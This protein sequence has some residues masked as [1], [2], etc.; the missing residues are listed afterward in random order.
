MYMK[1][2]HHHK[3]SLGSA[4]LLLF[5]LL[6][7]GYATA[8]QV[9][10]TKEAVYSDGSKATTIY[11]DNGNYA[12]LMEMPCVACKGSGVCT[13]CKGYGSM[14]VYNRISRC[15]S[16]AGIG[17]CSICGGVGKHYSNCL[18][19]AYGTQITGSST[20]DNRTSQRKSSESQNQTTTRTCTL[21]GGT[22]LVPNSRQDQA[23]RILGGE[24]H[25]CQQCGQKHAST[26]HQNCSVC[27]GTGQKTISSSGSYGQS[28]SQGRSC[29]HCN[30]T[31]LVPNS[32]QDQTIRILGGED[33]MCR[34]CGQKH[35]S[36][37]HES[38]VFCQGSGRR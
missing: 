29:T 25:M 31:G 2:N 12:I 13:F 1:T 30:G 9:V 14:R 21:C 19:D 16:C 7:T 22:G 15:T 24:D 28:Q 4:L 3:V 17:K 5:L 8:Q 37:S 10:D 34:Q 26:S 36:T 33:H 6:G 35:A 18:Y 23:I 20:L 11:Y 38:C 27:Q 32:R